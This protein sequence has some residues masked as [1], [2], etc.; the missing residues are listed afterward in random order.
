[1]SAIIKISRIRGI[2]RINIG[3][4]GTGGWC[5]ILVVKEVLTHEMTSDQRLGLNMSPSPNSYAEILIPKVI[6]LG[7]ASFGGD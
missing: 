7:S 2:L 5:H 4:V 6:V 3:V 1:M